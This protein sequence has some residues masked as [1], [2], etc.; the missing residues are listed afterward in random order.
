[1]GDEEDGAMGS[2]TV[3]VMPCV[4]LLFLPSTKP[5]PLMNTSIVPTVPN[6]SHPSFP[7]GMAGSV[8]GVGGGDGE[9]AMEGQKVFHSFQEFVLRIRE[10]TVNGG[11]EIWVSA[12]TAKDPPAP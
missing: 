2:R 6:S 12:C 9:R 11:A 8:L 3:T 10:K 7:V 1:M 5:S 4:L